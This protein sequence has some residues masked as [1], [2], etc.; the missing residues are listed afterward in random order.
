MDLSFID[1]F[2]WVEIAISIWIRLHRFN[3]AFIYEK[4]HIFFPIY[5]ELNIYIAAMR[6]RF[7]SFKQFC[8]YIVYIGVHHVPFNGMTATRQCFQICIFQ[9]IQS[10]Y[11]GFRISHF[12]VICSN[13][14]EKHIR[15]FHTIYLYSKHT[16]VIIFTLYV[17]TYIHKGLVKALHTL[18]IWRASVKYYSDL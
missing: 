11:D 2:V 4:A 13:T 5:H 8:F 9:E 10:S 1:S 6:L 7:C 18:H 17:S 16:V 15:S 12:C 3:E 14:R